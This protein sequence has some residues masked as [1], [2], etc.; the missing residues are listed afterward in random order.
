MATKRIEENKLLEAASRGME[1]QCSVLIHKNQVNAYC[2]DASGNNAMHVAVIRGHVH[3]VD[4]FLHIGVSVECRGAQG[5]TALSWAC[6]SGRA[7]MAKH[8]LDYGACIDAQSD[9]EWTALRWACC[10]DFVDVV[11]LLLLRGANYKLHAMD[12]ALL[13]GSLRTVQLLQ[14]WELALKIWTLMGARL[15]IL[16]NKSCAVRRLPSELHRLVFYMLQQH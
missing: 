3:I 4:L 6:V 5:M 10:Q 15:Q 7:D 11:G 8:L 1:D 2:T 16:K 13:H 9:N 12:T 14:D